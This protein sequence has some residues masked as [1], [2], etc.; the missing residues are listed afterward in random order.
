MI[1]S[2][3]SSELLVN[4][5]DNS[6][7][8]ATN[9]E[10]KHTLTPQQQAAELNPEEAVL[11]EAT[12]ILNGFNPTQPDTSCAETNSARQKADTTQSEKAEW[13][14]LVFQLLLYIY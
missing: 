12:A 11:N 7:A 14:D 3:D 8:E 10:E 6:G 9:T 13:H 2:D 5:A 4:D 1:A